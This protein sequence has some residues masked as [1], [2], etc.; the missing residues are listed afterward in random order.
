MK[1]RLAV[2]KFASCDGCQLALL[3]A[4][5][6]LL[7]LSKHID[8]VHFAEAGPV[9]PDAT[10]DIAVIEGSITTAHDIE[11]I[12]NI[13]KHSRFVMTI[14][15]CATSGGIQALRNYANVGE[16]TAAIYAQP[17]YIQTLTHSTPIRDHIHVDFE[18]WGCPV[19]TLQVLTAIRDLIS[20]VTPK[21]ETDKVCLECKRHNYTC[22]MVSQGLPCLGPVTR[23]GCG[24][25]CP[26]VGRECYGCYGPAE[27]TNSPALA[28]QFKEQGLKP[29]GIVKRFRYI[30]STDEN[31]AATA[32]SWKTK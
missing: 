23:C 8:I 22:V 3:N 25:L 5:E 17:H 19:N 6:D 28:T 30:H 15:A 2:H 31:F 1:P 11:R 26:S 16:W 18:L 10:V 24:A 13:R 29:A 21:D 27:N 9:N 4:G 20:G 7:H 32:D 12:T 14:G